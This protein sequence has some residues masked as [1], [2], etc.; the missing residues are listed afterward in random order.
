MRPRQAQRPGIANASGYAGLSGGPGED[1]RD[2]NGLEAA[3]AAA[4]EEEEEE[5]DESGLDALEQMMAQMAAFRDRSATLS[6][7]DRR[8]VRPAA[9]LG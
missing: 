4:E 8:E 9:A 6:D 7:E 2:G 3:A 5:G 1:Q